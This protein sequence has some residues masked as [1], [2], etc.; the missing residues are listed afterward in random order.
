M[1]GKGDKPR[2]FSV[3]RSQFDKNWD[4]IDWSKTT[5]NQNKKNNESTPKT[6]KNSRKI[7]D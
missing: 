3:S 4:N 2:P 1:N 5:N 7:S 6:K